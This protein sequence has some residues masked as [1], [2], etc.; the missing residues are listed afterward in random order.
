MIWLGEKMS[1][2]VSNGFKT[3]FKTI[4]EIVDWG[5]AKRVEV[6]K[7]AIDK[8]IYKIAGNF[9]ATMTQ[10]YSYKKLPRD[11]AFDY[12]NDNKS[13][14]HM[15]TPLLFQIIGDTRRAAKNTEQSMRRNPEYDFRCEVIFIPHK[16]EIYAIEFGDDKEF[17]SLISSDDHFEEFWYDGRSDGGPEI[18]YKEYEKR[19]KIWNDIF[20]PNDVPSEVGMTLDLLPNLP[21]RIE[22]E[23]IAEKMQERYEQFFN[24]M[25]RESFLMREWE[26]ANKDF[27]EENVKAQKYFFLVT[28]FKEFAE[29]EEGRKRFEE[30]K[31]QHK[32]TFPPKD[33]IVDIIELTAE[34]I[35]EKLTGEKYEQSNEAGTAS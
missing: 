18:D 12:D 29:S 19:G 13:E 6:E 27:V 31:N 15:E 9:L 4:E 16:G 8:M 24:L 14:L 17:Y 5:K 35:F 33:S 22:E 28:E 1:L 25:I 11:V 3:S 10:I 32:E 26:E 23:K 20:T 21:W 30:L 7:A 2:V 34:E